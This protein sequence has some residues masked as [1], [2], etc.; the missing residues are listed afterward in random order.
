M[1]LCVM[2]FN[3]W[4]LLAVIVGS[5]AGHLVGRPLISIALKKKKTQK[6]CDRGTKEMLHDF[7]PL[8]DKSEE[9]Y[10]RKVVTKS[11]VQEKLLRYDYDDDNV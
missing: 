4:I 1:M 2:T 6:N 9:K 3:L 11:L 5:G 10:H 7:E 8:N